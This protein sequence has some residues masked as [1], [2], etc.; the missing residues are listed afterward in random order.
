MV[1][2]VVLI[3]VI[4]ALIVGTI[5]TLRSSA[6]TGMPARDVLERAQR[7][8]RELEANEKDDGAADW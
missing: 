4:V 8:A 6:R 2:V 7:R 3:V 5:M 1:T